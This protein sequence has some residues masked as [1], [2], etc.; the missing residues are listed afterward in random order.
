MSNK[1]GKAAPYQRGMDILSLIIEIIM[2]RL[3]VVAK[4]I[5]IV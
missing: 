1:K 4:R 5:Q 2:I 3:K